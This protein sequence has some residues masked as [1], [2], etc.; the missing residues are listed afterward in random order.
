LTPGARNSAGGVTIF[1]RGLAVLFGDS[2]VRLSDACAP[3]N[4]L[5][6][7]AAGTPPHESARRP[8]YF[9][10]YLQ[11]DGTRQFLTHLMQHCAMLKKKHHLYR[12]LHRQPWFNYEETLPVFFLICTAL[13]NFR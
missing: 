1:L 12:V 8:A 5:S 11:N 10:M 3:P 7:C 4:V 13:S 6:V 9:T 2:S